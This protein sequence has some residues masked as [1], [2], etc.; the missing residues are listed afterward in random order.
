VLSGVSGTLG[1]VAKDFTAAHGMAHEKERNWTWDDGFD[2]R[3]YV[4]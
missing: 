3:G 1:S 4:V 2:E